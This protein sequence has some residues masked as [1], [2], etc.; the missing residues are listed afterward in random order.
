MNW[1]P[2]PRLASG[3]RVCP[4]GPSSLFGEEA[5]FLL[6]AAP[7]KSG[8]GP[9]VG[10]E[11]SVGQGCRHTAGGLLTSALW[12]EVVPESILPLPDPQDIHVRG[13]EP[14]EASPG[15]I[16][17]G[18]WDRNP[19]RGLPPPPAPPP[20]PLPLSDQLHRAPAGGTWTQNL[21]V[22]AWPSGNTDSGSGPLLRGWGVAQTPSPTQKNKDSFWLP[23]FKGKRGG[24]GLV[25][26]LSVVFT[27][28]LSGI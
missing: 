17:S 10:T 6:H 3:L 16:A 27:V 19:A 28:H 2:V 22:I 4:A 18:G 13:S 1:S 26:C 23:N 9:S 8:L 5:V 15:S 12:A 25:D 21:P 20:Q 24:R 14:E 7:G 11:L